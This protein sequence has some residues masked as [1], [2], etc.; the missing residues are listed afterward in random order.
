VLDIKNT[1]QALENVTG[2]MVF[3]FS[4]YLAFLA[5]KNPK[6]ITPK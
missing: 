2:E 4:Q 5:F 3:L 6:F 1:K